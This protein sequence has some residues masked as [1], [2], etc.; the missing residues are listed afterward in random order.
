MDN[1][2]TVIIRF[3]KD[4]DEILIGKGVCQR[5]VRVSAQLFTAIVENIIGK[6]ELERDESKYKCKLFNESPNL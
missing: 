3:D 4:T 1:S 2:T 5:D 6:N